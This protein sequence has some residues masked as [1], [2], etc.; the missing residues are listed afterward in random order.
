MPT[1]PSTLEELKT[2]A[3]R[4]DD[5]NFY[6]DRSYDR[7][8]PVKKTW[9]KRAV[10]KIEE[11]DKS[12]T[13]CFYCK[14]KGHLQKDCFKRE[15]D[16]KNSKGSDKSKNWRGSKKPEAKKDELT[17]NTIDLKV[18]MT[19][20]ALLPARKTPGS[21]GYDIRPSKSGTIH[22]GQ[23][24]RIPTS[25]SITIPAGHCRFIIS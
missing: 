13:E 6:A 8:S 2:M 5:I 18:A 21:A 25:L 16:A 10:H 22:P 12:Q 23:E 24:V 19:K 14:R 17:L 20:D 11:T 1:Q 3:Q 9:E 7:R 4:I 15:R